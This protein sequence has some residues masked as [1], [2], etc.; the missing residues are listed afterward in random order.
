MDIDISPEYKHRHMTALIK[1]SKASGLVPECLVLNGFE[2]DGDPIARGGF[3]DVYKGRSRGQEMAL[4]VLRVY[5][6]SDIQKL[7]KV[8]VSPES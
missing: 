8:T 4:K 1:L 2:V 5:Q 3:G 7:L 6:K